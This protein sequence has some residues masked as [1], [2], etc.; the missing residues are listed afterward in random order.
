MAVT[1]GLG[2]IISTLNHHSPSG[3]RDGEIFPVRGSLRYVQ[4]GSYTLHSAT[5]AFERHPLNIVDHPSL[6]IRTR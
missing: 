6:G 3:V 2:K 4:R 5:I 1:V